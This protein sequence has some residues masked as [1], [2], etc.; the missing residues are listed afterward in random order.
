MADMRQLLDRAVGWYT[1]PADG[2]EGAMRRVRRRSR[3]RRAAAIFVALAVSAGAGGLLVSAFGRSPVPASAPSPRPTTNAELMVQL[4]ELQQTRL[5]QERIYQ[6]L[7]AR[8]SQLTVTLNN[9]E[10]LLRR[11]VRLEA[12]RRGARLR[13]RVQQAEQTLAATRDEMQLV[14]QQA[15]S[16]LAQIHD[17]GVEITRLED[18]LRQSA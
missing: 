14:N 11:L 9:Q 7:L 3:N 13:A 6:E 8:R 16:R 18:R 12:S 1:P 2:L 5:I 4:E 17:L 15:L 10:S